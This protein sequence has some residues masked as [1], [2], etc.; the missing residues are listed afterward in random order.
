MYSVSRKGSRYKVVDTSVQ[1]LDAP[2]FSALWVHI[3]GDTWGCYS[4][5]PHQVVCTVS[6][7]SHE[8]HDLTL[9]QE[10]ELLETGERS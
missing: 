1:L 5:I 3:V 8:S 4:K 6:V 7:R 10:G 2:L 9:V